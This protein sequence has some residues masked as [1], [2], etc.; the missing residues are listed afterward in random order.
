MLIGVTLLVWMMLLSRSE[1]NPSMGVNPIQIRV[2][3]LVN[4]VTHFYSVGNTKKQR[5][6]I[7][8]RLVSGAG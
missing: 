5:K 1:G 2:E 8:S 7:N 3:K 4:G 6:T